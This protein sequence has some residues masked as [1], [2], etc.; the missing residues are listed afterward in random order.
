MADNEE[1]GTDEETEADED[2]LVPAPEGHFR[3]TWVRLAREE[4]K[5]RY[6]GNQ[7]AAAEDMGLKRLTLRQALNPGRQRS[8]K[9]DMTIS[10]KLGIPC[11]I[12]TCDEEII[13]GHVA[14]HYARIRH[15]RFHDLLVEQAEKIAEDDVTKKG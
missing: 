15:P 10:E 14:L 11:P 3:W 1:N 6:D 12:D 9:H 5:R 13:R 4:I 8:S 2:R 7:K